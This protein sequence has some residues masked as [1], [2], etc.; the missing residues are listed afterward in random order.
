MKYKMSDWN[1]ILLN[2]KTI[3]K[4]IN[5]T[6]IPSSLKSL[7]IEAQTDWYR[8]YLLYKYG[9]LWMDVSIILNDPDEINT[10]YKKVVHENMDIACFAL[11]KH[12]FYNN[13][14]KYPC[15]ESWCL[16][17]KPNNYIIKLWL[18]EFNYAITIGFN[19]YTNY[20]NKNNFSLTYTNISFGTYHTIYKCF[21]VMIQKNKI[22]FNNI[23]I[24]NAEKTMCRYSGWFWFSPFIINKLLTCKRST[25][26]KL[27]K[28]DRQYLDTNINLMKQILNVYFDVPIIS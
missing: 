19:N 11:N 1:L 6:E 16:L 13:S 17:S 27:I 18:D 15:I 9:G 24:R 5:K 2:E 12:H 25:N 20:I 14:K 7:N 22:D 26:T 21:M 8:L 4:L 3:Y 28:M 23:Y 10:M